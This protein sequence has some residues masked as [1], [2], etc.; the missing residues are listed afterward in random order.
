M[1]MKA[2]VIHRDLSNRYVFFKVFFVAILAGVALFVFIFSPVSYRVEGIDVSHWQGE[3]NWK[4]VARQS[5]VTFAFTKATEGTDY[6]DPA[7]KR[8]FTQGT[9]AGIIMG[10]YHYANPG[11]K[12]GGQ[13]AITLDAIA[14]AIHFVNVAGW[15]VSAGHLRPVLDLENN[16][17]GLSKAQLSLWANVYLHSVKLLTGYEPLIYTY[18]WFAFAYLN[19]SVTQHDLWFA[20]YNKQDSQTGGP[21]DTRYHLGPWEKWAFWQYTDSGSVPGIKGN[22]DR[23]VSFGDRAFFDKF[24]IKGN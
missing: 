23:D 8:N 11:G 10:A 18:A 7:F 22:V 15:T 3:I 6:I 20:R 19:H 16:P 2:D 4:Q 14:E 24:V 13:L 17:Q 5:N 1:S 12:A 9:G 21:N